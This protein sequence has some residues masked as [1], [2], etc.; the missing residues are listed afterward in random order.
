M[1]NFARST[2]KAI[3]YRTWPRRSPACLSGAR[4]PFIAAFTPLAS[5]FRASARNA[6]GPGV[7]F[8]VKETCLATTGC[9]LMTRC[10][11]RPC[12]ARELCRFGGERGLASMYPTFDWSVAPGHHGYQRA[13]DLISGKASRRPNGSPVLARAGK[14]EP[15]CRLVLSQTSAGNS[16]FNTQTKRLTPWLASPRSFGHEPERSKQSW[17]VCWQ[18]RSQEHCGA[19]AS[20]RPRSR[21]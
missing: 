5:G 12:V 1:R 20:S 13:C 18:A 17:P 8:G 3:A 9:R 11:V 21:A 10:M 4:G 14:T 6:C 7:R 16:Q 15:P 19:A 2:G